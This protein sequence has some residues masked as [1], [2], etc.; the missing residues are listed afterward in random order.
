MI[1]GVTFLKGN[2]QNRTVGGMQGSNGNDAYIVLMD[3][4]LKRITNTT[5]KKIEI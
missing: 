1:E 5:F 2:R 3:E 4:I